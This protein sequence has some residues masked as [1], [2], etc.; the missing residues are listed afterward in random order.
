MNKSKLLDRIR[1]GQIIVES[2]F[3]D[4]TE[5]ERNQSGTME[6]WSAKDTLA[7]TTAWQFRW[8]SWLAPLAD[9]KPLA[10]EGPEPVEEEDQAN[11]KIFAEYQPR[12]WEQI[13]MAYQT[14]SRGILRVIPL[15][16]EEDS[17]TPGPFSWLKDQTLAARLSGTF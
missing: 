2:A 12:P 17:S 13:H 16:S 5:G 3:G 4:L 11:S 6:H 15:L 1:K 7:H 14:A 9:D 8:V 10:A